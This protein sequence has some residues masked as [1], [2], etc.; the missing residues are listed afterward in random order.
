M[1]TSTF[2][3][4]EICS[5]EICQQDLRTNVEATHDHHRI[6]IQAGNTEKNTFQ[7]PRARYAVLMLGRE[8]G[9]LLVGTNTTVML[10]GT[11]KVTEDQED[12]RTSKELPFP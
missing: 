5:Q 8:T 2:T 12:G 7:D 6:S 1:C 3:T 4:K 9:V 10:V 11:L